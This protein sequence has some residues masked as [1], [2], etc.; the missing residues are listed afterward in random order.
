[1][2]FDNRFDKH[3]PVTYEI[4][5]C[6][7]VLASLLTLDTKDDSESNELVAKMKELIKHE[8][9]VYNT[10]SFEDIQKYTS[11]LRK[12][13]ECWHDLE[14]F[15][16]CYRL[17][18]VYDR[19]RDYTVNAKDLFPHLELDIE[20]GVR[21]I[22]NSKI[23]ID[24]YKTISNKLNSLS[25]S[26]EKSIEYANKLKCLNKQNFILKLGMRELAE[27]LLLDGLFDIDKIA[28]IDLTDVEEELSIKRG[29]YIDLKD[30]IKDKIYSDALKLVERIE[31]IE[32]NSDDF[33]SIYNNLFLTS[34]L[35]VLLDYLDL[36]QLY[37]ISSYC[38]KIK[39]KSE[40]I[41]N[42]V[43]MLIKSKLSE[44]DED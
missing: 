3:F 42:K 8:F 36:D 17:A 31:K 43:R 34:H 5:E 37:K 15:R 21:D 28:E 9:D 23:E 30:T 7:D 41:G 35:E 14:D 33:V 22:I 27:I 20:L 12:I 11:E 40:L 25:C 4:I 16:I 19:I 44:Y 6:Y 38:D 1:M 32:L 2:A 39:S 26:D 24:T 29:I 18:C 10:L 13:P